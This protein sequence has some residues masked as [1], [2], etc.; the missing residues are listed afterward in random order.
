MQMK[1][2][3]IASTVECLGNTLQGKS[4]KGGDA[5]LRDYRDH[6]HFPGRQRPPRAEVEMAARSLQD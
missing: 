5:E 2:G 1:R 6:R 3:L 4:P